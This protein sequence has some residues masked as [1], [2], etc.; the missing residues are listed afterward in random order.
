MYNTSIAIESN[1]WNVSGSGGTGT[2][3]S[4]RIEGDETEV[5]GND[6]EA[7]VGN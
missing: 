6:E 4:A 2:G 7:V 1:D 5:A 3:N